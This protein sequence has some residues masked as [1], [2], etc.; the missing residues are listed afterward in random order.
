[1]GEETRDLD[2][3]AFR[4]RLVLAARERGEAEQAAP[5]KTSHASTSAISTRRLSRADRIPASSTASDRV[6]R[7]PSISGSPSPRHAAANSSSSSTIA[8]FFFTSTGSARSAPR[9]RKRR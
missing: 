8:S 2:V 6:E 9:F 5:Q 4:E 3:A 7:S 1:G